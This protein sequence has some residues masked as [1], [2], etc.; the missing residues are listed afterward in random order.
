MHEAIAIWSPR[1]GGFPEE[2]PG[3]RGHRLVWRM[4]G[5]GSGTARDFL[6][7]PI[8]LSPLRVVL[9]SAR[10]PVERGGWTVECCRSFAPALAAGDRLAFRVACVP[11]RWRPRPDKRRGAREHLAQAVRRLHPGIEAD[12]DAYGRALD[13]AARAWLAMQGEQHGFRIDPNR[14]AVSG[15]EAWSFRRAGARSLAFDSFIFEGVLIVENPNDVQ[16]GFRI[17]LHRGIG[18]ERAF[19]FGL[20]QVAPAPAGPHDH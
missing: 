8:T 5:D 1:E 10:P 7:Q 4:F 11:T 2:G 9:R 17:C 13:T 18:A 12:P 14:L 6:Y 20:L 16:T 3:D 19:G 15:W